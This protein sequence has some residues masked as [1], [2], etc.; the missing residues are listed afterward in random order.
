MDPLLTWS[1]SIIAV[2]GAA[3]VLWKIIVP[4]V[5]RIRRMMDSLDDFIRDWAGEA[6]RPGHPEVPGVMERLQKIE[7]ELKHNGGSS[8]KDAVKRIETK[9]TKIDERLEEGN[10]R[11]KEI[12]DEIHG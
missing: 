3:T 10:K 9:L 6:A 4:I 5:N 11:F 8:I 12:E 1:A 7:A 2:G